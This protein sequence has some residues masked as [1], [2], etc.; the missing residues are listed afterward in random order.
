MF[1]YLWK[2]GLVQPQMEFGEWKGS[3]EPQ[4]EFRTDVMDF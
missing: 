3:D 1:F 2:T 4:H